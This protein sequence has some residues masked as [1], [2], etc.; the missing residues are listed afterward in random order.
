MD[1]E[2]DLDAMVEVFGEPNE[3]H[4]HPDRGDYWFDYR[5]PD[6]VAVRLILGVFDRKVII[7]IDYGATAT[8][9]LHLKKCDRV[10]VLEVE[11]RTVEVVSAEYSIRCFLSLDGETLMAV[12]VLADQP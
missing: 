6:G 1:V 8:T 10:R 12:D 4:S 3:R 7:G 11:R 5:R 2:F 9:S